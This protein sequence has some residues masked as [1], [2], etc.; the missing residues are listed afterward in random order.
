[1]PLRAALMFVSQ[2]TTVLLQ[3]RQVPPTQAEE[4]RLLSFLVSLSASHPHSPAELTDLSLIRFDP[5]YPD[6][7]FHPFSVVWCLSL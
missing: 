4:P 6:P 1:M 3:L 2:E 5:H 7:A